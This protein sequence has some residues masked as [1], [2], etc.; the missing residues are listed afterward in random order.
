MRTNME[1][2]CSDIIVRGSHLSREIYLL[3]YVT[4]DFELYRKAVMCISLGSVLSERSE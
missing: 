2:E 3:V 4:M 1:R